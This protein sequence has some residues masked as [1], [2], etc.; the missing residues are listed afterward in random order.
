MSV[1]DGGPAFPMLYEGMPG[2][3]CEHGMSLRDYFAAVALQA[4]IAA[5]VTNG[6]QCAESSYRY[7]DF[8]LAERERVK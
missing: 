3:K 8:M 4:H 1:K 7:A 5:K 6:Q 2:E